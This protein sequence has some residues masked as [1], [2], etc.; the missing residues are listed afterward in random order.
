MGFLFSAVARALCYIAIWVSILI[1]ASVKV[2]VTS[3]PVTATRALCCFSLQQ[4]SY[5]RFVGLYLPRWVSSRPF[6]KN[7]NLLLNGEYTDKVQESSIFD[8][9]FC[10][11][12]IMVSVR[13]AVGS[14]SVCV[15]LSVCLSVCLHSQ[16]SA[17][18]PATTLF[19]FLLNL[20]VNS[21]FR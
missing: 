12:S 14:Q 15:P 19:P 10:I 7:W 3:V 1:F 13:S 5:G 16:V 6:N 2:S 9:F 20:G 18:D 8:S 4:F 11:Q 21:I 17:A